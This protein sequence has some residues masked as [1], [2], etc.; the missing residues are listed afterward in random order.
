MTNFDNK[1]NAP[2]PNSEG[3]KQLSDEQKVLLVIGAIL[4]FSIFFGPLIVLL[5]LLLGI[6]LIVWGYSKKNYFLMV[7]TKITPWLEKI[8]GGFQKSKKVA[9]NVV[10]K[11]ESTAF[12]LKEKTIEIGNSTAS[13]AM[14]M[15][16]KAVETVQGVG[17]KFSSDNHDNTSSHST[18][19]TPK[20]IDPTEKK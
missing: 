12:D 15:R 7:G 9:E 3:K 13:S 8:T 10:K 2:L 20:D 11:T 4:V 14:D 5:N 1:I 17:E 19:L 6:G 16:Q 18:E